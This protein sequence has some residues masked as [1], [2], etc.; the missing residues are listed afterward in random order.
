MPPLFLTPTASISL[1]ATEAL[2]AS[3]VN[4]TL[5]RSHV[6]ALVG[7]AASSYGF[8]QVTN[9]GIQVATLAL[10]VV[11]AFNKQPLAAHSAYYSMST[12]GSAT[13]TTVPIPPW[14]A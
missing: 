10:S 14:N 2:V 8:F 4:L 12:N 5:P 11:R 9:H 7:A 13:Y 1:A 6:A 3:F